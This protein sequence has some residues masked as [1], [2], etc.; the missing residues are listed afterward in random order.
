MGKAV[1][2]VAARE[3]LEERFGG[4][5]RGDQEGV[6]TSQEV[7][8]GGVGDEEVVIVDD[9]KG[10]RGSGD[11]GGDRE[12]REKV[13]D[14]VIPVTRGRKNLNEEVQQRRTQGNLKKEGKS[15]RRKERRRLKEIDP[16]RI[17]HHQQ[18]QLGNR[19]REGDTGSEK[20][21]G[22]ADNSAA[23]RGVEKVE[24]LAER[25][26]KSLSMIHAQSNPEEESAKKGRSVAR[27]TP[28]KSSTIH[29]GRIEREGKD[30][31]NTGRRN[32]KSEFDSSRTG[33]E[34]MKRRE[35]KRQFLRSTGAPTKERDTGRPSIQQATRQTV[36]VETT[37]T[38][39][40]PTTP[41]NTRTKAISP[42]V[43]DGWIAKGK[44]KIVPRRANAS[45]SKE[46]NGYF[47][48]KADVSRPKESFKM[49]EDESSRS[50]ERYHFW[51]TPK[52]EKIFSRN[53]HHSETPLSPH[54][55]VDIAK[56]GEVETTT[57]HVKVEEEPT[58]SSWRRTKSLSTVGD[59]GGVPLV[60]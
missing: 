42:V 13:V 58:K 3:I 36:A 23:Q 56:R 11:G 26:E 55:P 14:N 54:D 30:D 2:F 34:D 50:K 38:T 9:G 45:S 7:G 1:R 17:A 47:P 37:Q 15:G 52:R 5:G 4:G 21:L 6:S 22:V 31:D 12:I 44:S 8:R 29:S 39:A 24:S 20:K 27:K 57:T 53:R 33:N 19:R 35:S 25:I 49:G 46:Q 32:K 28:K 51:S 10:M 59:N 16:N 18:Q 48:Y 40:T 60:P 43:M 41:T